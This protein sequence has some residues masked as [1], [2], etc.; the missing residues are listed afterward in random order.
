MTVTYLQVVRVGSAASERLSMVADFQ[1][2]V[3]ALRS[4]I[5]SA[6]T[7]AKDFQLTRRLEAL[8]KF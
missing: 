6:E 8:E 2:N 4:D 3:S 7:A 1:N 5:L